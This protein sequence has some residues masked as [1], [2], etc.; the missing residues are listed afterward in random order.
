MYVDNVRT[1]DAPGGN[2]RSRMQVTGMTCS[3]CVHNIE[4]KLIATKGVFG[5]SVALAT[6][7][8]KIQFDPEVLGARD[9]IKMIQVKV[10]H[11]G[12]ICRPS[13]VL[14]ALHFRAWASRPA[15]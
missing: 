3:S 11:L 8:A 5:A 7:R 14:T 2:G 12:G 6:N 13:Y 4:S 9:I 1:V 10:K 15:W